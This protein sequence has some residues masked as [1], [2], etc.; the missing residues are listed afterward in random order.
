MEYFSVFVIVVF[1]SAFDGCAQEIIQRKFEKMGSSFELTLVH[2]DPNEAERLI[3]ESIA[4]IDRIEQLI[5]SWDKDSVEEIAKA[6]G[7]EAKSKDADV[8]LGPTINLH[9]HPLG[10]RHFECYSEDP[11]LTGELASSYVKGVQSVGVS[12]CLKHFIGNDTEYQRHFVSSN[13][14]DRTLSELYLLPFD[15]DV[16]AG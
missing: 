14:D 10:G 1:L 8:L 2:D 16:K 4:E 5:S 12:A 3:E 7:I 15:M 11:L 9:R 6:I 13:L